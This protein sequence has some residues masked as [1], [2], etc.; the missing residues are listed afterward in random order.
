MNQIQPSDDTDDPMETADASASISTDEVFALL[1]NERRRHVLQHLSAN[2]GEAHLREL[3]TEIAAEEHGIAPV[4]VSYAQ[5]K[6]L[7]TSL[8]QSHLPRMERSRVITYDRNTGAVTLAPA[9]DTFDAYLEIVGDDEFTWSEFYLGLGA[10]FG[11]VTIA[12]ATGTSPFGA[13]PAAAVM[14]AFTMLLVIAALIHLR[15]TRQRRL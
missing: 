1:S 4:E 5:R 2:G 12:Y 15:Y 9:A 14:A 10:L 13:V 11:A 6:R 8:Y 3:A 7:Y